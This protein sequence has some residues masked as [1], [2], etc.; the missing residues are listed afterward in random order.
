MLDDNALST[1]C[2]IVILSLLVQGIP[3]LCS[4]QTNT[5]GLCQKGTID[6][7]ETAH[8]VKYDLGVL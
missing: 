5:H 2:F 3:S 6:A 8:V 7:S 4:G 1:V